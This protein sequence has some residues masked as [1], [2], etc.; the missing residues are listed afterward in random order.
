MVDRA[1]CEIVLLS[2][3]CDFLPVIFQKPELSKEN[4]MNWAWE[5]DLNYSLRHQN[6]FSLCLSNSSFSD[7]NKIKKKKIQET[8]LHAIPRFSAGSC[9]VHIGDHFRFGIICGLVIVWGRGSFAALYSSRKW[10]L[11]DLN[12]NMEYTTDWIKGSPC[13]FLTVSTRGSFDGLQ[14]YFFHFAGRSCNK[15]K[16]K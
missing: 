9:T 8:K 13:P 16:C 3:S 14:I 10:L 6:I 7:E 5:L 15:K 2:K 11:K 1:C 4:K 12:S